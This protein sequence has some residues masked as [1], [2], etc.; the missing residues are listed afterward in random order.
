MRSVSIPAIGTGN[1]NFPKDLVSRVLLR[2]VHLYS[3]RKNPRHLKEV[4]FVVH[5]SD[6]KTYEVSVDS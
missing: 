5:P 4:V 1:L 6:D 2:E 3:R